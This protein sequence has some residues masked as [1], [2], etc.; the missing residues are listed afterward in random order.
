MRHY[1][2]LGNPHQLWIC[3]VQ[4]K[5]LEL[6]YMWGLLPAR[7]KVCGCAK[8]EE[9]CLQVHSCL[10]SVNQK[11]RR[12]WFVLG[13]SCS[14]LLQ[15]GRWI[16]GHAIVVVV[17]DETYE[18]VRCLSMALQSAGYF[19]QIGCILIAQFHF[20]GINFLRETLQKIDFEVWAVA[21]RASELR[22]WSSCR[23]IVHGF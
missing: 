12:W 22:I 21:F 20:K 3:K 17:H 19:V 6:L 11:C 16:V 2:L 4:R 10:R 14:L 15:A 8:S 1:E 9:G 13:L 18:L 7:D 5:L 23:S